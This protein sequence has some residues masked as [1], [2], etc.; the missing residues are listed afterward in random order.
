MSDSIDILMSTYNGEQFIGEQLDSIV[1][2]SITNWRLIIR[3]DGSSD[4]TRQIISQ[5][6]EKEPNKI[7]LVDD[8]KVRLGACQSFFKLMT[9]SDARYVFFCDQDD[10][11]LQDKMELQIKKMKEAEESCAEDFPILLH[12][13]LKVVDESLSL[14]SNSLWHYQKINPKSMLGLN[15][16]L[17]QN[18]VTGC[19]VLVNKPLLDYAKAG[20]S[21]IIM[22]DWWML[23]LAT[24]MGEVVSMDETT[25]LYRQHAKNDIGANRWS[26]LGAFR[27]FFG[28]RGRLRN[29][30]IKTRMQAKELLNSGL[31]DFEKR[32]IIDRYV[33]LGDKNY[34]ARRVELIRMHFFKY[35]F[36]RNIAMFLLI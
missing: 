18:Y 20:G 8:D 34:F 19:S 31:L 30:L 12:S 24:I 2:Q 15:R 27:S 25:V 5:Y 28:E 22:H 16:A 32:Q 4:N 3:D 35:G 1:N 26:Y 7:F 10:V 6:Q 17:V 21:N 23:L 14:I 29:S 36:L 33:T 11:W 9:C 13:D